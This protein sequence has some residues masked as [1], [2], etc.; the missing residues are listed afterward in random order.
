MVSDFKTVAQT[1]VSLGVHPASISRWISNG[2][3]DSGGNRVRLGAFRLG[4]R[5]VTTE[6][7]VHE[8]VQHL[9]AAP[10]QSPAPSISTALSTK[11]PQEAKVQSELNRLGF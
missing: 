2:I 3:L 7:A 4:G 8:F 9:S 1:A 6:A 5:W 11:E 10:E